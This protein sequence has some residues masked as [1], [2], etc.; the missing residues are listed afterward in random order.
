MRVTTIF[1][2]FA[3]VVFCSRGDGDGNEKDDDDKSSES[4]SSSNE[5]TE[6]DC[7]QYKQQTCPKNGDPVCGTN[8]KKYSSECELCLENRKKK[9]N[10]G[11][12]EAGEC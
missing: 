4:N 10:I 1:L 2:L 3:V 6:P 8:H 11:I 7:D 9:M 5:G 12:L